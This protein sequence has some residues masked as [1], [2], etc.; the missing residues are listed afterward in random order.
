MDQVAEER[1]KRKDKE[2]SRL[3]LRMHLT[4]RAFIAKALAL[5]NRNHTITA[6]WLGIARRTLLNK[7]HVFGL[8]EL[9]D[10]QLQQVADTCGP[11]DPTL[12]ELKTL[13]GCAL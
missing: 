12:A 9:T 10:A 11:L 8:R 3:V 2:R 7:L 6:R 1:Q 13:D 5:H 4:E